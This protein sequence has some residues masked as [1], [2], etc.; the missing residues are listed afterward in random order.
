MQPKKLSWSNRLVRLKAFQTPKHSKMG[1]NTNRQDFTALIAATILSY[2]AMIAQ[3]TPG[4][5]WSERGLKA[6]VCLNTASQSC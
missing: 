3:L 5:G 1:F 2:I 6:P 4:S